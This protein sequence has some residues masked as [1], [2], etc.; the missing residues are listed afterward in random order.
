MLLWVLK[1]MQATL[2]ISCRKNLDKNITAEVVSKLTSLN[3]ACTIYDTTSS[4][5]DD[6]GEY[7]VEYGFAIELYNI[8]KPHIRDSI[9]PALKTMLDLE[10]AYIIIPNQFSGC[11]YDYFRDTVCPLKLR[12]D[13]LQDPLNG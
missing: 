9:W 7:F 10:C 2:K 3:Q 1:I 13:K 11:I 12:K 5:D 4:V 8:T 6:S